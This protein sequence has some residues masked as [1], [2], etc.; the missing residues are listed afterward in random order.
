MPPPVW[1]LATIRSTFAVSSLIP[2]D[3]VERRIYV[4]RGH[5]IMLS[6][7]LA[8][9][10]EVEHRA[11]NQAVKR[12][13]MRFPASFMFQL[14]ADEWTDLKSQSVISRSEWG[15][16]R[17]PPYAFTE[18]GVVMLSSVL[19]SD[20]AIQV[21]IMVVEAF[22]RLREMLASNVELARRLDEMEKKYDNQFKTVF[23][24]IR[25]L[26]M[27]PEKSTGQIGFKPRETE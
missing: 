19:Q 13:S 6:T 16:M 7:D 12:N 24:A 1:I 20:R 25:H 23:E 10:Y 11:L 4:L 8:L 9:L 2:I 5:R 14:T 18:H 15:G 26:M 27:H 17:H 21:S 3:F 22:V